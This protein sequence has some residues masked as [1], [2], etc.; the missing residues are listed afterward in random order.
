[1]STKALLALCLV[2]VVPLG[3]YWAVNIVSKDA[4]VMPKHF[5]PDSV[6]T[7]TVKGKIVNDTAWHTLAN[8]SLTNQL[9]K[10][11]SLRDSALQGKI[12]V[13]DFFFTHCPSICPG[14]TRNMRKMQQSLSKHD[15]K[16]RIDTSIVHF[17]SFS[18]DPGRDS[19][20][21]LKKWA[22]RFGVDHDNW[23]LLTGDKKT[24]YD[25][26]LNEFKLG[27]QDGGN[28]DSNFIHTDR[29]ILI[30]RYH[31]VRG[32]YRGLDSADLAR[33]AGD[34]VLLTLEKDKSR[35]TV[36]TKMRKVLPLIIIGI[37]AAGVFVVVLGRRKK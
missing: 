11:V 13:A 21:A 26:S 3:A 10:Q 28:V 29:F 20:P 23:W 32:F 8:I 17:L 16:I 5:Y 27:L 22:D 12:I 31:R 18:V 9:G 37:V 24:I 19:V 35:P 4:V 34:I 7:K 1:V 14:L 6:V 33:L 30:D 25:Y 2:L 15:I 36:F